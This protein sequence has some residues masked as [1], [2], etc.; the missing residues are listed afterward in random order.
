MPK[1]FIPYSASREV[2][3]KIE[4]KHGVSW[5]E[6]EELFQ[7]KIKLYRT[8]RGDQYGESRY[9]ALGRSRGGRYLAVFFVGIPPDQAK[10]ITARDMDQKEKGWFKGK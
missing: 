1:Y 10:V 7:G 4:T 3:E 6:I 9:L 5:N 8:H 2:L